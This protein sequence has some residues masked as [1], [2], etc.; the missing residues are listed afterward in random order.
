MTLWKTVINTKL[1]YD[2]VTSIT[3]GLLALIRLR[4]KYV[5]QEFVITFKRFFCFKDLTKRKNLNK[6]SYEED[7][8]DSFLNSAMNIEFV[9]IILQGVVNHMSNID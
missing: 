8:L 2:F 6:V 5:Y 7:S 3:P 4:E 9:Y 1:V